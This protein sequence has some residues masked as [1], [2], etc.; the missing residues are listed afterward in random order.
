MR[1][2]EEG[3]PR[4]EEEKDKRKRR[5]I[6]GRKEKEEE[7]EKK[8]GGKERGGRWKGMPAKKKGR[9]AARYKGVGGKEPG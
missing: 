4:E 9:A 3:M 5:K 2:R 6:K 7:R 8:E 1:G